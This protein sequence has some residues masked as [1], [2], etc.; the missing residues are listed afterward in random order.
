MSKKK[1]FRSKIRCLW[2]F[3]CLRIPKKVKK[4]LAHSFNQYI[5]IFIYFLFFEKDDVQLFC[6]FMY[7]VM[8]FINGLYPGHSARRFVTTMHSSTS[9]VFR[10]IKMN[11]GTS[12]VSNPQRY[13]N[14]MGSLP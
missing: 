11:L 3:L 8:L 12:T 14:G 4:T 7:L 9:R 1:R 13:G 2:M 5:Y 6:Y 10:I